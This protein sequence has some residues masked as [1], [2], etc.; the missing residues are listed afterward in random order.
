MFRDKKYFLNSDRV[1]M[2]DLLLSTYEVAV[3]RNLDFQITNEKLQQAKDELEDRVQ[4]RTAE[5]LAAN[6]ELQKEIKKRK[7]A[8]QVLKES[9]ERYRIIFEG[10]A[11]GILVSDL[12]TR[13]FRYCNPAICEMLGYTKEELTGLDVTDIHPKESLDHVLSV[14]KD[15]ACVDRLLAPSLPCLRKDGSVIFADVQTTSAVIHGRQC[16]VGFFSD[17]TKRRQIEAQ[18]R[19]AQKMEA[20]GTLAGGVA[21]DFNNILT[22]II[23]YADLLLMDIDTDMVDS[24]QEEKSTCPPTV[25]QRSLSWLSI[26][27]HPKGRN[28]C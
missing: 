22:T 13:R 10:T 9:E 20:I 3:Q 18:L 11:E 17:V 16:N 4:E 5:L 19:Q 25:F 28:L 1:Q 12:E 24:C 27:R 2:I 6:V 26:P 23:G 8:E 21:H 15:Q 14:F 7:Q